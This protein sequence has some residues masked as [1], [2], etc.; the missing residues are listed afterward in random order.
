MCVSVE[1]LQASP[2]CPKASADV[3]VKALLDDEPNKSRQTSVHVVS[4]G[5]REVDIVNEQVTFLQSLVVFKEVFFWS[6]FYGYLCGIACGILVITSAKQEWEGEV[7]VPAVVPFTRD[8]IP[9]VPA[10]NSTRIP[11]RYLSFTADSPAETW[12]RCDCHLTESRD[13]LSQDSWSQNITVAF[14]VC[15]A[16]TNVL[17][18]LISTFLH[19]K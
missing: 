16:S 5:G 8:L 14:S 11:P 15:S 17:S 13:G 18:P 7:N 19:E 1:P 3:E 10:Q 9:N 2:P 4:I 6:L 12:L